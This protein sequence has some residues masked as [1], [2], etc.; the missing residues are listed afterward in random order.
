M[1]NFAAH[2]LST[3]TPFYL[4]ARPNLQ[5]ASQPS[6]FTAPN[7]FQRFITRTKQILKL[8]SQMNSIDSNQMN[9]KK[10]RFSESK[11]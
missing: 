2:S 5:L 1:E 7:P 11:N 4:E 6:L 3:S 8:H 9:Q 10:N